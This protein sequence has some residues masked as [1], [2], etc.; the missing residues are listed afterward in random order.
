MSDDEFE[1]LVFEDGRLAS[2]ADDDPDPT[3]GETEPVHPNEEAGYR[4]AVKPGALE[5]N[6]PLVDVCDEHG[7]VLS[8]G[9]RPKAEAFA[10][11]LSAED[12]TLRVQAAAPNDLSEDDG[13]LLAAYDRSVRE[14]AAVDGDTWTF[15]VGANLYG[16]LGETV[17]KSGEKPPAIE[18]FV[19]GDLDAYPDDLETGLRIDVS[20]DVY[21]PA[22]E[23]GGGWIPDCCVTARDGWN[24]EVLEEYWCEIKTGDASFERGQVET[25]RQLAAESRVLKIR[26]LIDDLPDQYSVRIHEVESSGD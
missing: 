6:E 1:Q 16:A 14:P 3:P 21:V 12:G 26:V 20:S 24:G 19:E 25:M 2:V 7:E 4:L 17:V 13:Y 23:G 11:R 8:F 18:Y 22:D 15:D 9:S 10:R 5:A